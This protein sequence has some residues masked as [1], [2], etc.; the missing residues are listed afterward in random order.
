MKKS[1]SVQ[2]KM[3][4]GMAVIFAA[5]L[6]NA[7][8][9]TVH[10]SK[11]ENSAT[12]MSDTYVSIQV[13]YGTIEKKMETIQKYV[14]ILAGSSDADLKIAGDIYG[15]LESESEEVEIL[16]MKLQNYSGKIEDK[17]LASLYEQYDHGCI[18]LI[19]CMQNC[20][21]L[22]KNNGI[23]SAKA[24]LGTDAMAAILEQEELCALLEE[25]FR[26][27]LNQAQLTL[28][29]SIRAADIS[30]K[31]MSALCMMTD[32][33]IAFW[34][35]VL[36]L[37]PIKKI[38]KKMQQV[39]LEVKEGK[40]NL[41][42]RIKVKKRDEVGCLIESFNYLLAA[43]QGVTVQIRENVMRMEEISSRSE[44]QIVVSNNRI[45]ELSSTMEELSGGSEEAS[46]LIHQM[47]SEM[48]K[49]SGETNEISEEMEHGAEF[50]TELKE[51][52]DFIRIK[53]MESKETAE[54]IAEN[55]RETLS[56]SIQE[57]RSIAQIGELTNTI[58]EIAAK[59]NLLALNAAIEAAR[60]G[61]AGK[62]FAVVADEI[63]TLA[64][65][66]KQ[67]ANAIQQLNNKVIEAVQSLCTCSEK[68][69]GFVDN[70]VMG[71]YRSFEMMAV[72]YS[73]DAKAVSEIMGKVQSSVEHI[74]N[75]IDI[76]TQNIA[77]IATSV[78]ESALGIQNVTGN[79]ID[80]SNVTGDI[81]EEISQNVQIAIELKS[82]SEGFIIEKPQ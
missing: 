59:T 61:E 49:I 68:M 12:E 79:V 40:G 76:V 44:D 16:L 21:E 62:G 30:N 50:S 55:I 66:S 11:I 27:A 28:K 60:A 51:R 45:S 75:Q 47:K 6:F 35:Y 7:F 72:R 38:S 57:S 24:Y 19:E 15:R 43:F 81:C 41:T 13:L 42:V 48:E 82:I 56:V 39:A 54:N 2:L 52:A 5:V 4:A 80:I 70:E 22:R 36:L 78:E 23:S 31:I 3:M 69:V 74:N 53:T 37:N 34:V 18:H 10:L 25:A 58:L 29:S 26:N 63:R 14:N 9:A 71:D 73:E 65:N 33:L 64:D 20:S 1:A 77:G 8:F 46:A 67:N 32:V 17:E